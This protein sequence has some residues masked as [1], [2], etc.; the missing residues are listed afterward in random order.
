MIKWKLHHKLSILLKALD[1]GVEITLKSGHK[2]VQPEGFDEPGFAAIQS[3]PGKEDQE[4][5]FQIGS[6]TAWMMLIDH[7]KNMTDDEYLKMAFTVTPTKLPG[8]YEKITG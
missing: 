7:A 1:K 2:L 3:S 5:V 8:K 6:E 4:V